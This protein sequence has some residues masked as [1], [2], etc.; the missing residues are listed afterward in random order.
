MGFRCA[1]LP[2]LVLSFVGVFYW[3]GHG[4][5]VFGK[6]AWAMWMWVLSTTVPVQPLHYRS[7]SWIC[8]S[9][10][11]HK[12]A[13]RTCVLVGPPDSS[14]IETAIPVASRSGLFG[15]ESMRA[16]NWCVLRDGPPP[17]SRE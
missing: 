4:P 5:F 2:W 9:E 10:G 7:K 16:K 8:S 3:P 1:S 17:G 15:I 14:T 12:S 11:S 13:Y 6:H